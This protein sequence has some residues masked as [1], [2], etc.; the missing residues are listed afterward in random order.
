M[1]IEAEERHIIGTL[2]IK[3]CTVV[4]VSYGLKSDRGPLCLFSARLAVTSNKTGG[5][6]NMCP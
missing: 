3:Y 5:I 1:K 4:D 6:R 2:D